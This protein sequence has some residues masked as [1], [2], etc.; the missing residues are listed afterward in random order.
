MFQVL[1]PAETMQPVLVPSVLKEMEPAGVTGT[2]SGGT[3]LVEFLCQVNL[4]VFLNISKTKGRT[5]LKNLVDLST[6]DVPRP[7]PSLVRP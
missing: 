6:K 4:M 2:V 3:G 7:P 5:Q 1:F